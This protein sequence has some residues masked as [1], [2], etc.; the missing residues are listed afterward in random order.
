MCD[1]DFVRIDI[2]GLPPTVNARKVLVRGVPMNRKSVARFQ[3][4]AGQCGL[5]AMA[6]AGHRPVFTAPVVAVVDFVVGAHRRRDVDGS[7]KD[8][9]DGLQGTVYRNDRQ[10][11]QLQSRQVPAARLS[12]R[13]WRESTVVYVADAGS[14]AG[15]ALAALVRATAAPIPSEGIQ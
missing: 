13:L 1:V 11:V 9:L 14:D 2:P 4:T 7:L 12:A 6:R 5:A 8:V 10:I 3:R 15:A